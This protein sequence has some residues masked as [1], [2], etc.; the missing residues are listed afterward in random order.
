VGSRSLELRRFSP[1]PCAAPLARLRETAASAVR[2]VNRRQW[3]QKS[4][5]S[6]KAWS[7]MLRGR[8]PEKQRSRPSSATKSPP[9]PHPPPPP[10]PPPPPPPP[11]PRLLPPPHPSSP[12]A[13]AGYDQQATKPLI[14]KRSRLS[15]RPPCAPH[16]RPKAAPTEH[17]Y[18]FDG[19]RRPGTTSCPVTSASRRSRLGAT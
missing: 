14:F 8:G 1:E 16:S 18:R 11:P 6:P 10:L 9:A 3:T 4:R 7:R 12:P 5:G 19:R 17:G 13:P 15:P 2:G